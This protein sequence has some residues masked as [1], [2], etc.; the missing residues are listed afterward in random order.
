MICNNKKNLST[1]ELNILV[2]NARILHRSVI[3]WEYTKKNLSIKELG[4]TVTNASM[5]RLNLYI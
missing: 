4:T 2:I 1:T 5:F 3:I